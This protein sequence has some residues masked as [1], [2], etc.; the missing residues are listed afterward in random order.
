M[1]VYEFLICANPSCK[2]LMCI[3][4]FDPH[5]NLTISISAIITPGEN[6]DKERIKQRIRHV[7]SP[8][9]SKEQLVLPPQLMLDEHFVYFRRKE[10]FLSTSSARGNMLGFLQARSHVFLIRY[11]E[12]NTISISLTPQIWKPGFKAV[13]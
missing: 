3:Y 4:P 7:H 12:I 5:K 11:R 1:N 6:W 2:L 9:E 8:E 13:Q 10:H